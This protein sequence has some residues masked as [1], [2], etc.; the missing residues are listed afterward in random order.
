[1]RDSSNAAFAT[2]FRRAVERTI[3]ICSTDWGGGNTERFFVDVHRRLSELRFAADDWA[4]G[5]R[6]TESYYLDL[7]KNLFGSELS[8]IVRAVMGNVSWHS[9]C[10]SGLSFSYIESAPVV[11]IPKSEFGLCR[12]DFLHMV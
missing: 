11:G 9:G 1:V 7:E 2:A 6:R 8:I 5:R 10:D 3:K 4:S 12:K